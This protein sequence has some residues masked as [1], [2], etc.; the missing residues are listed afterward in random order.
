MDNQYKGL[1]ITSMV[2]GIVSILLCWTVVMSGLCA[3]VGA[4]LGVYYLSKRKQERGFA[5]AGIATSAFGLILSIFAVAMI[6]IAGTIETHV[7]SMEEQT[8]YY[9][10]QPYDDFFNDY[11]K[12]FFY[13]DD[14]DRYRDFF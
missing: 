9:E 10:E 12:D 6:L 2:L 14:T 7:P 3:V 8:P 1:G 11:Y 5:I 4:G 13:D